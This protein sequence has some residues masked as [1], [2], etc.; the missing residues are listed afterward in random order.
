MFIL[1]DDLVKKYNIKFNGILHVGAHEC[2]EIIFYEKYLNRN[3]ILWIDAILKKV[4][5]SKNKYKDLLIEHAVVS[6][7]KE[8][9]LFNVSNNYQSSSIF[10][11]GTHKKY[12]PGID[13]VESYY[14]ETELLENIISKY[15]IPI[16]FINLD[17][18][19]AELKALKG[20]ESFLYNIDYIYSEVNKD[21]V[22]K[23]C[24][25]IEEI[26]NY[27]K[28]FNFIRVETVWNRNETWGDAFYI[29]NNIKISLCI[30]TKN[31]FDNF[32]SIYLDKYMEYLE[33]KTIDEIIISDEDGNDY[34]KII[35]KY[36]NIR[37]YKNSNILGV[38]LNKLKVCSYANNNYIAL[39]DSDNY[40]EE[41]YFIEIKKYI[42]LNNLPE[43]FIL[44]PSFAKPRFSFKNLENIILTKNNI[45]NY[46]EY[47]NFMML[48]NL[49]NF[50]ITKNIIDNIVYDNTILNNI[51]ACDV[52]YF[53]LL[54][55]YFEMPPKN[56]TNRK[57]FSI[58]MP[59]WQLMNFNLD[60]EKLICI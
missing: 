56:F 31:R 6:D 41:S 34:N 22:Y 24:A 44:S 60:F 36:K 9:V 19:G 26:D 54:A 1:L 49:G 30:P 21:Y 14:V 46:T 43:S 12:Y 13:Y 35:N 11:F 17:I 33:N 4:N 45:N 40:C 5:F 18:Q 50:V 2:E 23:D 55:L 53:N 37:I 15:D 42:L 47:D 29:K 28:K 58:N 7:K 10:E 8:L 39:I 59:I 52:H 16:N 32:L 38:F 25:L 20:M 3:Q 51:S 27:L 48:M 57:A